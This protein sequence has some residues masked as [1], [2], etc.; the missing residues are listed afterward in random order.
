[1]CLRP[2]LSA[3]LAVLSSNPEI[4]DIVLLKRLMFKITKRN[5]E[6]TSTTRETVTRM[7]LVFPTIRSTSDATQIVS[8]RNSLQ[9]TH[10]HPHVSALRPCGILHGV[11]HRAS[12]CLCAPANS[13][14]PRV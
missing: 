4:S 7:P 12:V 13:S 3:S 9:P 11:F 14:T 8:T 2:F 6:P 1:M 5:S 10:L